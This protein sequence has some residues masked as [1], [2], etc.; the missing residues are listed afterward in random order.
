MLLDMNF[1]TN[2]SF[3]E[4]VKYAWPYLA[5]YIFAIFGAQIP[6]KCIVVEMWRLVP[7]DREYEWSGTI[8]GWI[9]R[10][11]FLTALLVDQSALI[12]L[13]MGIKVAKNLTWK[14]SPPTDTTSLK[15]RVLY[16]IMIN[17]S[18]LSLF[19]SGGAYMFIYLHNRYNT[20]LGVS[21]CIAVIAFSLI[22]YIY[23]KKNGPKKKVRCQQP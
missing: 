2:M 7:K 18:F 15:T 14:E 23:A 10:A 9:E 20:T 21:I 5:A 12:A 8:T 22:I 17:A 1:H 16:I 19:Y 13:W 4:T 6:I 11:L 3:I